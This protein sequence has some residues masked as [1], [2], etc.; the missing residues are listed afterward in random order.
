MVLDE[1]GRMP[2]MEKLGQ[3]YGLILY[4]RAPAP[5]ERNATQTGLPFSGRTLHDRVQIFVDGR[6]VS[7]IYRPQCGCA[8]N[9]PGSYCH[10]PVPADGRALQL[11]VENCGRVNFGQIGDE[12]KGIADR[13][14][15]P[16][17]WSAQCLSLEPDAVQSLPFQPA[18]SR[19]NLTGLPVFWRGVLR[20]GGVPEDTYLDSAG[21]TKGYVW[22]NGHNLGRYWETAGPQHA[23]Y[24][25]APFLKTGANEVIVLDLHGAGASGI[26]SVKSQ[27]WEPPSVAPPP[28]PTPPASDRCEQWCGRQILPTGDG[29][30]MQCC[31]CDASAGQDQCQSSSQVPSCAMGCA[32]AKL[33]LSLAACEQACNSS[34]HTCDFKVGG[35]VIG[36]TCQMCPC[37]CGPGSDA[38]GCVAGCRRAHGAL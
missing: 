6:P 4:E 18:D 5:F 32:A 36:D 28:L 30:T 29:R 13:P 31:Q 16:G 37:G 26:L 3:A 2:T 8:V 33:T 1:L 25:P 22:V 21:L 17:N 34:W 27:R 20:I 24:C 10:A 9:G 11:L 35:K 12:T 19:V 14:P 15:M 7:T 38:S 23:L